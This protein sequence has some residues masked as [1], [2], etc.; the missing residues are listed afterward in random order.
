MREDRRVREEAFC[1][2]RA[3]KLQVEKGGDRWS[4]SLHDVVVDVVVAVDEPVSQ[5]DDRTPRDTGSARSLLGR[6]T[7]CRFADNCEQ[8]DESKSS[9]RWVS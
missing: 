6:N 8:S 1:R 3:L 7:A 2:K 4:R 9:R 5:T